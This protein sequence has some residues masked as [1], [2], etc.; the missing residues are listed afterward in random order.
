MAIYRMSQYKNKRD[1]L[2]MQITTPYDSTMQKSISEHT[3]H[4]TSRSVSVGEKVCQTENDL[5]L[6]STGQIGRGVLFHR[7]HQPTRGPINDGVL[8]GDGVWVLCVCG[9]GKRTGITSSSKYSQADRRQVPEQLGQ[10]RCSACTWAARH[11]T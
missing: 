4:Q 11:F 6:T 8:T 3:T 7:L 5:V 9:R 10:G 2:H 1:I